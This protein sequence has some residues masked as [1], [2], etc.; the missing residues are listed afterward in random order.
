MKNYWLDKKKEE[1]EDKKLE[2]Q[3]DHINWLDTWSGPMD[4][5]VTWTDTDTTAPAANQNDPKYSTITLGAYS[6]GV[7]LGSWMTWP[8]NDG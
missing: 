6:G 5:F 2:A 8:R 7:I 4:G 3:E 1:E